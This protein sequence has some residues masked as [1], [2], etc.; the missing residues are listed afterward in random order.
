M[1]ITVNY[2]EQTITIQK[3][4]VTSIE[5][6]NKKYLW[7]FIYDLNRVN[8]N[9]KIEEIKVFDNQLKDINMTG[10]MWIISDFFNLD[11][12]SKKN[13]TS[14]NKYIQSQMNETTIVECAKLYEKLYTKFQ[15]LFAN[16]DLPICIEN[17]FSV[18][19]LIKLFKINF[20]K[21]ETL[22][23]NLLLIID[24][25]KVFKNHDVIVLINICIF[26]NKD[27]IIELEKYA[28]YNQ[29]PLLLV[30]SINSGIKNKY[31]KKLIIDEDL[32]ESVIE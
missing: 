29:V 27:E 13:I 4:K 16:L 5:I 7:R 11:V 3:D 28:I 10:K 23:E 26:L 22:L 2:I 25:E 9:D 20:Y 21:K 14:L 6:L 18:D 19:N 24:I 15:N 8:E 30:D 1:N 32:S 31:E 17:E 12:N